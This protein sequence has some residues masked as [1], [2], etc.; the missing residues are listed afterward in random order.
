MQDVL[1]LSSLDL[2]PDLGLGFHV[3]LIL[4]KM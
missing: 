3:R 4:C 1:T 2:D